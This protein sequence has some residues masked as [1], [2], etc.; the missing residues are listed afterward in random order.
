MEKLH[1]LLICLLFMCACS[2]DGSHD[3]LYLFKDGHRELLQNNPL[4]TDP[5]T[6]RI[7][8][9]G[10]S[11]TEDA[12][13]YLNEMLYDYGIDPDK[14]CIYLAKKGGA[15]LED[16]YN[17]FAFGEY[18]KLDRVA[19]QFKMKR[20]GSFRQILAQDW[21]IVTLQQSSKLAVD[22]QSFNPYLTNLIEIIQQE[23]TNPHLTFAWQLAWS[24]WDGYMQVNSAERYKAICEAAKE[25]V[26]NDGIDIIIPIGTAIENARRTRLQTEH[27]LTRDGT[28]IAYGVGRYIA[29]CTWFQ[30]LLAPIYHKD[31]R[32]G[33]FTHKLTNYERETLKYKCEEVTEANRELC[34]KCA[35]Y[36]CKKPF[37]VTENME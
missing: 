28:H 8:A 22:Y 29:G 19:G 34:Q 7:L 33:K 1:A 18:I 5:E 24:Y 12:V 37:V 32:D 15:S 3:D 17:A 4:P 27:D 26:R 36:S 30:T 25:Q 13:A 23:C 35:F 16:W 20:E 10:N 9:I 21:D 31:V 14:I 2:E 11:Y 6:L